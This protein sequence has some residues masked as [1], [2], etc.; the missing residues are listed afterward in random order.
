MRVVMLAAGAAGMICGSCLRDNRVALTLRRMGRD[1][2]LLPLYTPLRTDEE[3]ADDARVQFGGIRVYLSEK[4]TFFRMVP[5]ALTRWLDSPALLR[6]VGRFA[7]RTKPAGV[8]ALT[9]SIL[10]GEAGHQRAEIDALCARLRELKPAVV[11]LPNLMFVGLTERLRYELGAAIVCTLSGEDLFLDGL[12]EPHRGEAREWIGRWARSP[13]AFIATSQYYAGHCARHF[14]LPV[15]RIQVVPLGVHL[16]TGAAR[17]PIPDCPFRIAYIARIA[18]EKGLHNLI[19]ALITLRREG[20]VCRVDAA[21]W[22]GP[23]ERPYLLHLAETVRAAGFA[24]SFSYHGEVSREKKV[25]LISSAHVLSVPTDY[26]EAKGLPVLEALALGT[27][28]VQ[29]RHGAFPEII[30]ATAGVLY[31]PAVAEALPRELARM[32]DDPLRRAQLGEAGMAA[33][34]DRFSDE[35]MAAASWAVFE[36]VAAMRKAAP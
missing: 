22:M 24:D 9:V 29:P 12:P 7:A 28:V 19:Q 14:G 27:P 36:S 13:D 25:T 33:V 32:M 11:V 23:T 5:D 30:D 35:N 4:S 20:R 21:G 26:H 31:D 17:A 1:V 3:N 16:E 2:L 15:D 34:R 6:G 8:G 10:K 18:P